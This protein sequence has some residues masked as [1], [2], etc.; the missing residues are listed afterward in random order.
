MSESESKSAA[1]DTQQKNNDEAKNDGQAEM[2]SR[3]EPSADHPETDAEEAPKG[4]SKLLFI[5][6][7]ILIIAVI[8]SSIYWLYARQFE[9]TDDAFIDGDIVQI[10]P[11]VSAYITKIYVKSNQFV[12]KATSF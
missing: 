8:A 4:R 5:G 1:S 2:Q 12:T 9:S 3:E 10:S 11:K 6:V 7:P